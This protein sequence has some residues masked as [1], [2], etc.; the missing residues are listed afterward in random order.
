MCDTQARQAAHLPLGRLL[1]IN[2]LLGSRDCQAPGEC[3]LGLLVCLVSLLGVLEYL[4]ERAVTAGDFDAA[5]IVGHLALD[6][7]QR[8]SED[9]VRAVFSLSLTLLLQE[10]AFGHGGQPCG[11]DL[12]CD[13]CDG[14]VT[15][16][17]GW[18]T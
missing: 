1:V 6:V 16:A 14:A 15:A 12:R 5:D 17:A 13:T 10:Y 18:G 8:V 11:L 4:A 7:V 3:L 2:R 9:W